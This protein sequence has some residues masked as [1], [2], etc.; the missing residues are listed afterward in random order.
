MDSI[1]QYESSESEDE[2]VLSIS[3]GNVKCPEPVPKIE[4]VGYVSKRRKVVKKQRIEPKKSF[5]KVNF[6]FNCVDIPKELNRYNTSTARIA[7]HCKCTLVGHMG[8]VYRVIWGHGPSKHL[9]ASCSLDSTSRIWDA[10]R[11]SSCM[12]TL[13]HHSQ[14]IKALQWTLDGYVYSEMLLHRLLKTDFRRQSITGGLDKTAQHI[15]IETQKAVHVYKHHAGISALCV[16]PDDENLVL[17][18]AERDGIVCWDLRSDKVIKKYQEDFHDVQDLCFLSSSEFVSSCAAPY[19]NASE[20][21]ILVWDFRAGAV[22][23]HQ[24]ML[25]GYACP[26]IRVHPEM[27]WF[28]AQS[29][30]NAI[31]VL[32]TRPPYKRMKKK[33]F[34]GHQVAGY[35]VQCD[36]SGDGRL[37]VTGDATGQMVFYDS[38]STKRLYSIP[39]HKGP[40]VDTAFHPKMPSTIATAGWDKKIHIYE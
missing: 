19:R 16:H 40:C 21:T 28:V 8:P 13:S 29:S 33:V 9:L 11:S 36:F 3:R 6:D 38:T 2:A 26:A 22:L 4:G 5:P 30:E 18:G 15:D 24:L 7:R 34:Q 25:E 12:A 35:H 37:L 20:N 10:F 27:K 31:H 17:V 14:G 23:S 32:S 1:R 39:A